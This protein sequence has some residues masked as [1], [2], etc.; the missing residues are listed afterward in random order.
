MK[1]R[2][3]R[4]ASQEL[5]EEKTRGTQCGPRSF[6]VGV[7]VSEPQPVQGDWANQMGKARGDHRING[8]GHEDGS[9]VKPSCKR[10]K[11]P[12]SVHGEEIH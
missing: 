2:R 3:Q 11:L 10:I 5:G 1:P 7:M 8:P 6:K 4:W 9:E 12:S